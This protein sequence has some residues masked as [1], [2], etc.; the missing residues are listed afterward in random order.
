YQPVEKVRT[1]GFGSIEK[2]KWTAV[3]LAYFLGFI[4]IHKFYLGYKSEA[5]IMLVITIVG[6]ICTL[7]LGIVAMGV[8]SIIEAVKYAT[9]TDEDFQNTYVKGYKGWL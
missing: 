5:T 9:L 4:G 8:I 6:A 3:A 7:G 2:E 1:D